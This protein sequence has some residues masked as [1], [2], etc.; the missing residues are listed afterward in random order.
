P[1][2]PS[3]DLAWLA[4][5]L[6]DAGHKTWVYRNEA[7]P[8]WVVDATVADVVLAV[9]GG[10]QAYN[11]SGGGQAGA[12]AISGL[13]GAHTHSITIATGGAHAHGG[14]GSGGGLG[15]VW[16][17]DNNGTPTS[18]Y[19]NS[20]GGHT[21]SGTIGSAG[22]AVSHTG[23]WRPSAAVGTLQYPDLT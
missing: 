12:W 3:Y 20:A 7:T 17:M 11:V 1:T 6:G 2:R 4:V 21:H 10:T 15:N 14:G 5:L 19:T 18:M 8:G 9:K 13:T 16:G 22:T 23:T